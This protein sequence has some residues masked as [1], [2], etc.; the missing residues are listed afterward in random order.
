VVGGCR[1]RLLRVPLT[2]LAGPANAGKVA[3]LLDR[4]R[5]DLGRNPVLVVP[6]R[7]EVDRVERDLA[8]AGTT[9]VGGAIGTFDD[10]FE[11]ISAGIDREGRILTDAQRAL[12]VR[13]VAS[14]AVGSSLERTRR[15][16]GFAETLA[17]TLTE[18]ESA[19]VDPDDHSGDLSG[20]HRAYRQ[21]LDHRRLSDRDRQRRHAAERVESELDAWHGQ[22]VYAYGFEDLTGVQ[23]ALLRAL[24]GRSDVTVSLPYEPGRVAFASLED[25]AT[26]LAGLA[27]GRIEE[28]PPA[29]DRFAAPALAYLE[30]SL[31]AGDPAP[32]PPTEGALRFLEAAGSRGALELVAEEILALVRQGMP[33][34]R[35]A[36]VLPSAERLRAPLETAFGAF[37]IH[38][39]LEGTLRLGQTPFGSALLS[40]LRFVWLDGTRRDL[41]AFMRSP[42]SGLRRDHVDFLEGR[43]RGRAVHTPAR[44]ESETLRLRGEPLPFLDL[45]RGAASNEAAVRA[46]AESMLRQAHGVDEPPTGDAARLDLRVFETVVRLVTELAEWLERGEALTAEDIVSALERARVRTGRPY[47]AGRVAAL[48]LLAVR[49]RHYDV[50]FLL[51]LEEGSLPRRSAPA[52]LLDDATRAEIEHRSRG[53]RLLRTDPVSRDRYLFYTACTRARQRL[54]LVREAATEDGT[55]REPSPFWADVEA[56]FDADEV[57]RWT[58]RRSLAQAVWPIELAPSERERLRAT[59][60]LAVEDADAARAVARA[61][62]WERRMERALTAFD[63]PTRLTH[64]AVIRELE[65]RATF[66][67]TELEVF[68]DCSSMW[69]VERLIDP[70]PIDGRVDARLRGQVAHQALFRFFS[71]LPRRF[72]SDH[73][74]A[75]RIDETLD[76]LGECVGEAVVGQAL[77]RLELTDV[78]RLELEHSLLRDLGEYVRDE[79]AS[80]LP[81]VPRRFEVSFGT[82]RSAPE[83]KGGLDLG[84]FILS[85]KIDRVDV[86]PFSARGIVQ[87]YKS[88]QKAHSAA[89]IESEL[90]LQIPLYMLV[91][92]DL[93]GVEP[94]GGLYRALA[95]ERRARG[96]LRASARDDGVPGFPARDYLDEDDFWAVVDRAAEHARSFVARIRAGDVLHDPK[97][98]FPCPTW[99]TRWAMCRVRRA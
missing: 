16:S 43:L 80:E 69:L 24:A 57:A 11:R 61:N 89:Q 23:W 30:R 40:L 75:D 86:D 91:L 44:V 70:R 84:T 21:E 17:G 26:G 81:L 85:G 56:L 18:L 48:D 9:L 14:S 6:N 73:V 32:G 66:G 5:A 12:L 58:R 79:A 19:L 42:Y 34:E 55:P 28:L 51:G 95:G 49:T 54:Y 78:Q 15:F 97:G 62:G 59:A 50:V 7:A 65:S 92:R 13:Q 53:A 71:G 45:L 96:L 8:A 72:G 52:S 93:L 33:A 77:N 35:I 3:L 99:C 67:V 87:D 88:G 20:L 60:A 31:Y 63:R 47:E 90:R 25:T 76:F 22:P 4:Y 2:L 36:V 41:Y 27:D 74:D 83:L 94:I 82:E 37:G 68:A 98:G 46:V 1:S 39:S 10:L 38:H 29:S 64:P